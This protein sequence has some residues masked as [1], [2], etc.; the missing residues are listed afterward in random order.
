M[1]YDIW[2]GFDF[3][4]TLVEFPTP[5]QPHGPDIPPM[6][7]ALQELSKLVPIRIFTARAGNP[8]SKSIVQSRLN[9][10]NLPD[11]PITD[12]KDFNLAF[13]F[14]D[15]AI[16]IHPKTGDILTTKPELTRI[17]SMFGISTT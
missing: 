15:R 8:I 2:V 1:R 16:T 12:T 14:D 3:D 11:I 10:H 4:G 17:L 5:G 9:S 7:Y 13:F 6:V